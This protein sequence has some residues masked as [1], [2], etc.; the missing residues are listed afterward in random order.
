MGLWLLI[1][2]SLIV[3]INADNDCKLTYVSNK[4][5]VSNAKCR[6]FNIHTTMDR[7]NNFGFFVSGILRPKHDTNVTFSFG[8]QNCTALHI[9][10][11]SNDHGSSIWVSGG[12][13]NVTTTTEVKVEKV[14]VRFITESLVEV[15]APGQGSPL[16]YNVPCGLHETIEGLSRT[17]AVQVVYGGEDKTNPVIVEFFAGISSISVINAEDHSKHKAGHHIRKAKYYASENTDSWQYPLIYLAALFC[18][19]ICL[20]CTIGLYYRK[21]MWTTERMKQAEE[22][23][24]NNQNP[25]Q[26]QP[27]STKESTKKPP[28]KEKSEESSKK[29]RSKEEIS[30]SKSRKGSRES[31]NSKSTQSSES[32]ANEPK[33]G[34][35]KARR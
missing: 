21:R 31:V 12:E 29:S 24:K 34:D 35:S 5:R 10:H 20:G 28:E 14:E 32:T 13:N 33:S 22:E 15:T 18:L 11:A 9:R 3:N 2:V 17:V 19:M 8:N 16:R 26:Q 7:T 30:G 27:K 6:E 1:T 25:Q 23:A 4:L